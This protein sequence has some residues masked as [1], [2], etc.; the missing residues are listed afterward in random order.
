MV[1]AAYCVMSHFT[2]LST[3]DWCSGCSLAR[4]LAVSAGMSQ[5]ARVVIILQ[6]LCT[7]DLMCLQIVFSFR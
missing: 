7:F 6:R 2:E 4:R 5:Y 1:W 3:F